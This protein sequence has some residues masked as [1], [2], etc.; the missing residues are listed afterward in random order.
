LSGEETSGTYIVHIA[1]SLQAVRIVD[2]SEF[3]RITEDPVH[4]GIYRAYLR[5]LERNDWK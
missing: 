1:D 2:E 4:S 5:C 3:K